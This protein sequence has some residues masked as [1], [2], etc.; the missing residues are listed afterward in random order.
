MEPKMWFLGVGAT[1]LIGGLISIGGSALN[2]D[3]FLNSAKAQPIVQSLGR[4]GA[5]LFYIALGI[6]FSA[7]GAFLV[8]RGMQLFQA[9]G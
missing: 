9:G 2:L 8:F 6:A 7:L 3:V 1:C 4:T 5:R